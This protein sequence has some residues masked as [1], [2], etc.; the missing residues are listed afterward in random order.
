MISSPTTATASISTRAFGLGRATTYV[1]YFLVHLATIRH[2]AGFLDD[3]STL[4][5][6]VKSSLREGNCRQGYN[7]QEQ[8]QTKEYV[9]DIEAKADLGFVVKAASL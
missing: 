3:K 7:V 5:A 6:V 8:V 1:S 9:G 4:G 2:V